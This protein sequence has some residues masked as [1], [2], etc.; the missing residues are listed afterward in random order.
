[1]SRTAQRRKC[2]VDDALLT[3]GRVVADRYKLLRRAADGGLGEVWVAE[4]RILDRKVALK[5]PRASRLKDDPSLAR[6]FEREAKAGSSLFN[7]P[8]VVAVLDLVWTQD[9]GRRVPCVIMEWLSGVHARAFARNHLSR[10]TDH[11]TRTA[12]GLWVVLGAARALAHA[13]ERGIVH[14]DVKPGNVM[15]TASGAVK[16]TDFG[17]AKFAAERTRS[18]TAK[19]GG[20][21]LYAAPEQVAGEPASIETDAY[22]LGCTLYEMLEGRAPFEDAPNDA[23]LLRA[24]I[25]DIEPDPERMNGLAEPERKSIVR[26]YRGLVNPDTSARFRASRCVGTLAKILHR[27]T[28]R[29][30]FKQKPMPSRVKS[31]IDRITRY[32]P[33]REPAPGVPR[34]LDYE[35]PEEALGETTALLLAG[36]GPWIHLTRPG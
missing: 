30:H 24:K 9:D 36:A 20:T 8:H 13:H 27:P 23:A 32:E 10:R 3:A 16:L 21:L 7:H 31:A 29:M 26:L 5:C 34:T 4:D 33:P 14:R 25:E 19:G 18:V 28:W 1:V 35:D 15:V 22:Q 6:L 17:L 12:L 11:L 2:Y